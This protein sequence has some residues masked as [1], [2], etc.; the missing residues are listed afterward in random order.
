[1][2]I[3]DLILNKTIPNLT[4]GK[5][6][7]LPLDSN[8]GKVKQKENRAQ[9]KIKRTECTLGILNVRLLSV[10]IMTGSLSS[11]PALET[12]TLDRPQSD[13]LQLPRG[14]CG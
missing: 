4:D 13:C 6:Y 14:E 2:I 3:N 7:L 9:N 12:V 1:V 8:P 11:V 10:Q 5:S